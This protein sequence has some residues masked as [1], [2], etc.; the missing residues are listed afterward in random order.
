LYA[1]ALCQ[2]QVLTRIF[3]IVACE[4]FPDLEDASF[5]LGQEEEA[6]ATESEKE[7]EE[8]CLKMLAVAKASPKLKKPL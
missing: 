3:V 5:V 2:C 8:S 6:E 7:E 4:E 1:C